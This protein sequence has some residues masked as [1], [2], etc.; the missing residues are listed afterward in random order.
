LYKFIAMLGKAIDDILWHTKGVCKHRLES[1]GSQP[2]P[3][4]KEVPTPRP[5]A[6][7][8]KGDQLVRVGKA[9]KATSCRSPC[10]KPFTSP[11]RV[12]SAFFE[13]LWTQ[14]AWHA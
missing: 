7:C 4:K 6:S 11:T 3:K 10:P 1:R 12:E 9:G 8:W 5:K 2:P 13:W 14:A